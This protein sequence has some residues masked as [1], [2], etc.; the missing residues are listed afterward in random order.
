MVGQRKHIEKVA[1]SHSK[2][3]KLE[4]TTLEVIQ[5][6]EDTIRNDK[7][8]LNRVVDLLTYLCDEMSDQQIVHA[9]A[10]SLEKIFLIKKW[11]MK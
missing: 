4:C 10:R 5:S 1:L 11:F 2:K 8:C 6:L 3:A 7:T 9:A